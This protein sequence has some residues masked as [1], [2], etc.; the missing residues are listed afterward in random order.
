MFIALFSI[1]LMLHLIMGML[2]TLGPTILGKPT[3][4]I[5]FATN[6]VN[7]Y[8]ERL[9]TPKRKTE[10]K[11]SAFPDIANI[12]DQEDLEALGEAHDEQFTVE[13]DFESLILAINLLRAVMH[14]KEVDVVG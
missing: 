13:D 14:G 11:K 2:D 6:I 12:V 5:S 1:L 10:K 7:D 3:Q 8:V 9:L 4:I